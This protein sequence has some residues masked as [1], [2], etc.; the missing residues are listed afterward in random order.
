M[1]TIKNEN[2]IQAVLHRLFLILFQ[3]CLDAFSEKL[4]SWHHSSQG[5][6]I[7]AHIGQVKKTH[8]CQSSLGATTAQSYLALRLGGGTLGASDFVLHGDVVNEGVSLWWWEEGLRLLPKVELNS[9]VLHQDVRE[10]SAARQL[11]LGRT[12]GD[13]ERHA[14][15]GVA[16]LHL[17]A[18]IKVLQE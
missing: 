7:V 9:A 8:C 2:I 5:V 1:A 14:I 3:L 10:K 12:E 6:S 16:H 13:A 17:I 18:T 15:L 11:I 4:K